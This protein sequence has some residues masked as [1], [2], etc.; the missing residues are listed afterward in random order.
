LLQEKKFDPEN[1]YT[2]KWLKNFDS[3]SEEGKYDLLENENTMRPIIDLGKSRN[4]A[5]ERFSNIK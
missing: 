2:K 3:Y 1:L 5:L 4:I